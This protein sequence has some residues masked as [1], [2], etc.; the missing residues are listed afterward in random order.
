MTI[1]PFTCIF[2]FA[3]MLLVIKDYQIK[4]PIPPVEEYLRGD[5]LAKLR[6]DPIFP[7]LLMY[8]IVLYCCR[9]PYS[10]NVG[11]IKVFPN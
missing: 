9:L 6:P 1:S 10:I 8:F 2:I 4:N 7:F 3:R 11:Y 5:I